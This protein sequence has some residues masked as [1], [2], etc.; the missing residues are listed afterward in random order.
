ML[1]SLFNKVYLKATPTQVFPVKFAKILKN[2]FFEK[3]QRTAATL[4]R[5]LGW[6][7]VNK[8]TESSSQ[9]LSNNFER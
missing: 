3:Y 5:L 9:Y 1:E 2:T 4:S 7:K 6:V 8:M